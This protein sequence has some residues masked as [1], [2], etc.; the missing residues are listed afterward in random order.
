M[1]GAITGDSFGGKSGRCGG[2][3]GTGTVGGS[4]AGAGSGRH[5]GMGTELVGVLALDGVVPELLP[6]WP[7]RT[8]AGVVP[9]ARCMPDQRLR[10]QV[11]RN[12]SGIKNNN[13]F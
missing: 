13:N 11:P 8:L 4:G 5:G 3:T 1:F 6:R 12:L 10:M 2:G 9:R 7:R